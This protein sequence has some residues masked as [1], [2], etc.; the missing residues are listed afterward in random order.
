MHGRSRLRSQDCGRAATSAS[1]EVPCPLT[2][3]H[4]PS[5]RRL[6]TALASVLRQAARFRGHAPTSLPAFLPAPEPAGAVPTGG[7]PNAGDG[8]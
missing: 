6:T 8:E 5:A 7:Q 2:Y 1:R 3:L 4:F